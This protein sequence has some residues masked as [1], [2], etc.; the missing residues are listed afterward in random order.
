MNAQIKLNSLVDELAL[1]RAE[2]AALQ[3]REKELRELLIASGRST[4]DGDLHTLKITE[5]AGRET[6][7]WK[8]IAHRFNPSRQL[9]A[10]HTKV[11]QPFHVLRLIGRV[12][13]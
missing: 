1:V 4:I 10:A 6:T 8:T 3:E 5:Q 2:I 13:Q 7:D 9:I 12:S 11:G